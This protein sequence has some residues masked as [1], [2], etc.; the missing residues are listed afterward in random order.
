[1]PA[2]PS[3]ETSTIFHP[4]KRNLSIRISLPFR[5]PRA[6]A[7]TQSLGCVGALHTCLLSEQIIQDSFIVAHDLREAQAIDQKRRNH[8]NNCHDHIGKQLPIPVQLGDAEMAHRRNDR[9]STGEQQVQAD[10]SG[11]LQQDHHH[12]NRGSH[13]E[14]LQQRA[15]RTGLWEEERDDG[16]IDRPDT[17]REHTAE[18]IKLTPNEGEAAAHR[19]L[20]KQLDHVYGRTQYQ[21]HY[22]EHPHLDPAM[23]ILE[24]RLCAFHSLPQLR[25]VDDGQD[26]GYSTDQQDR[27]RNISGIL[28]GSDHIKAGQRFNSKADAA[29]H[30]LKHQGSGEHADAGG[31]QILRRCM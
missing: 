3:D 30:H 26:Q 7:P 2:A 17:G 11:G 21:H 31:G 9:H 5:F 19:G 10:A 13:G 6:N 18:P 25:P 14:N 16:L 1:M 29:E 22:A 15:D 12:E 27:H 8:H 28:S 20:Q 23:P 4:I 24:R